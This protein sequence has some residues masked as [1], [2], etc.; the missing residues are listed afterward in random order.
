MFGSNSFSSLLKSNWRIKLF[1]L[2]K[3]P[4]AFIAGIKTQYAGVDSSRVTIPFNYFTKNPFRSMYF[5]CQS[6]AAEFSTAII[7]LKALERREEKFSIIV[8][9]MQASFSK[10]ATGITTFQ[11][12]KP[13]ELD[14]L[15][16]TSIVDETPQNITFKSVGTNAEGEEV[17]E[18]FFTW[19]IKVRD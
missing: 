11:C 4:M 7:C 13:K 15:I 3:L 6:M 18:F 1:F 14:S 9:G 19:S 8:V 10:K 2:K 17:A 5:A 16:E 12:N